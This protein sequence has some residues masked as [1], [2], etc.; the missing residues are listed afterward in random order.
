MGFSPDISVIAEHDIFPRTDKFP[1]F[2]DITSLYFHVVNL[3]LV[4]F[5]CVMETDI[6]MTCYAILYL[7]S[8]FTC[9][10]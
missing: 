4:A 8:I 2:D 3:N 9:T 7:D 5:I 6:M 10:N 1:V